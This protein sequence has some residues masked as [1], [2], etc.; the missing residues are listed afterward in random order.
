MPAQLEDVRDQRPKTG[1]LK[2]AREF[3]GD[4]DVSGSGR[5]GQD[6]RMP[7]QAIK[8]LAHAV[9]SNERAP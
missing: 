9:R 7:I 1:A 3:G 5:C 8:M 6:E 4:F 2:P